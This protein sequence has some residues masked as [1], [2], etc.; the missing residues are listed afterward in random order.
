MDEKK[1]IKLVSKAIRKKVNSNSSSENTKEWDSLGHLSILSSLDL[2]T[3]GKSSKI[4]LTNANSIKK[5][6]QKLKKIN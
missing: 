2:L 5:L 3:K 1:I 4:N 6:N